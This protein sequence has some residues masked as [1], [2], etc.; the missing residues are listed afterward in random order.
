MVSYLDGMQWRGS[1]VAIVN[2][3]LHLFRIPTKSVPESPRRTL[4]P[5]SATSGAS[6]TTTTLMVLDTYLRIH[7]NVQ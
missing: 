7:Y 6:M 4:A 5:S 2:Q 3:A 1:V